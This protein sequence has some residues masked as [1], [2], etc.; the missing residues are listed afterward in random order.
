MP[1]TYGDLVGFKA[2]ADERG[3]TY[4][5]GSG[6]DAEI[7]AALLRATG[8]LDNSY[9]TQWKGTKT[10]VVQPL[11]WPRSGVRDEDRA[12]LPDDE[13]PTVVIHAA[14]EA[15]RRLLAGG[16]LEP[17]LERGGAVSRERVKAGP[18]EAETEYRNDASARTDI[19][20]ISGLLAGVLRST[21]AVWLERV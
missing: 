18:V 19:T 16:D 14:Y 20:S 21:S 6:A 10:S 2:W 3:H 9:R 8:F 7:E 1:D 12:L 13:I 5:V 17:D 15:T 11:A 4:P